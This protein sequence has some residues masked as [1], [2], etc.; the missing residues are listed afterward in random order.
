MEK[1]ERIF[2]L[3][4]IRAISVI[5]IVTFHF[6][7]SLKSSTISGYNKVF[8]GFANGDWGAIGVILFFIISGVG[9]MH[10]YKEKLELKSYYKKRFF[11][12]YP[13]FWIAYTTL[14]IYNFY[15]NKQIPY[16]NKFKLIFSFLGIDGYILYI[17]PNFYIIGEWFLGAIILIYLAFPILRYISNKFPKTYM[18]ILTVCTILIEI[19]NPFKIHPLR[20]II[21]CV[22]SFSVGMYFE[23]Y[24]KKVK[25]TYFIISLIVAIIIYF[26]KINFINSF[27]LMNIIGIAIFFILVYIS[28]FIKIQ[29]IKDICVYIGKYSYAIF[30]LHHYILDYILNKFRGS[31]FSIFETCCLYLLCFT[32]ILLWSKLLIYV[33]NQI[34]KKLSKYKKEDFY[35][36]LPSKKI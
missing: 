1:K 3:D 29:L 26:W 27:I 33:T 11:K 30:L 14:F 16:L 20:N 36:A 10:S 34:I 8:N 22:F 28:N 7:C 18:V 9:L 23:K 35:I 2:Y 31:Y 6:N 19:F 13:M 21:V 17:V 12:I 5:I 24:I 15:L 32:I 25:L 4:F